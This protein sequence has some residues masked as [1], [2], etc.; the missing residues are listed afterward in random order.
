MDNNPVTPP[1]M[2]GAGVTQPQAQPTEA[3]MVDM[4][5]DVTQPAPPSSILPQA[6]GLPQ[7][8]PMQANPGL[9]FGSGV[10]SALGG[11]PAVNPYLTQMQQADVHQQARNVEMM[12]MQQRAEHAKQ[13][14]AMRKNEA[15]LG[16]SQK[17]LG[18]GGKAAL[19]GAKGIQAYMKQAGLDFPD[20][21][22]GDM[23]KGNMSPDEWKNAMVNI[24][25][26]APDSVLMTMFPK[27]DPS[28]IPQLRNMM[29]DPAAMKS[30][31]GFTPDDLKAK[32][33]EDQIKEA[34]LT[35]KRLPPE[36]RGSVKDSL[37]V[38]QQF[39][40]LF[41]G[42]DMATASG[43]QIQQAADAAERLRETRKENDAERKLNSALQIQ[44]AKTEGLLQG[45]MAR[46][47]LANEKQQLKPI[48]LLKY[49]KAVEPFQ[50]AKDSLGAISELRT[51]VD[52]IPD[53]AYPQ[54]DSYVSQLTA[55]AK[56]ASWPGNGAWVR[57]QQ[58]W[59]GVSIGIIDRGVLDEKNVRFKGAFEQQTKVLDN[60]PPKKAIKD[61]L[62]VADSLIKDRMRGNLANLER[63]GDT[64]DPLTRE[65]RDAAREIYAPY[66]ELP[67]V[68]RSP[69]ATESG[70]KASLTAD[71]YQGLLRRGYS[72]QQIREKYEVAQ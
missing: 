42:Q 70:G 51:L 35:E 62:D 63:L 32:A 72:D 23:V 41:P 52:Q 6:P 21:V 3:N 29:K 57:F 30:V 37:D 50:K 71:Q 69:L 64:G 33:I 5:K 31:M 43:N 36:L 44:Q 15:M 24:G 27:L 26:G 22:I 13:L 53:W 11:H 58:L 68:R 28:A 56:R 20:S 10:L 2:I 66:G 59:P 39:R 54:S 67:R 18:M 8:Q 17:L 47:A 40:T 45:I 55:K 49:Q 46:G 60:L 61:Y 19:V 1:S 48:D 7:I 14:M 38:R 25:R 12:Q 16:V 65:V 4:L 9:G 34:E